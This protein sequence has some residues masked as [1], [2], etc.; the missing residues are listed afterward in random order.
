[1]KVEEVRKLSPMDRFLYWIR[2]RHNIYLRRR[3]GFK[4]PWTDDEIL[5]S[6]F[7]TNPYRENDKVTVWFRKNV[8]D[9]LRNDPAVLFATVCFRWFNYIPTGEVLKRNDL[10]KNWSSVRAT[11]ALAKVRNSGDKVFTGAYLIKSPTGFD[12]VTGICQ[13]I[14]NVWEGRERLINACRFN[15]LEV[16]WGQLCTFPFLGGFMSYEIVTDI[17][18][19]GLLCKATDI[20]TWAHAGPGAARG[21]VRM[22]GGT[23]VNNSSG[24]VHRNHPVPKNSV[25]EIHRLMKEVNY[26]LS[27]FNFE[28]RDVEHSLCEWDKY[29]RLLWG[30]GRSKRR[31]N[32]E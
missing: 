26:N 22:S 19:T 17:R 28:M 32:G 11:K 27:R 14:Q 30:E 1:M 6:Y 2:E 12:K 29:E 13:C 5:Q 21:L 10:L 15:S 7:F 25:L 20:M 9:P 16:L 8:R 23:P 3:A 18:H 31:Y 4:K 24:G